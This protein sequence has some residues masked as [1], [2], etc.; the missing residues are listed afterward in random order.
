MA[1]ARWTWGEKYFMLRQ[2]PANSSAQKLG[3]MVPDGWVAYA[4]Q[5]H[6]F[7]KLFAFDADG[8]YP[9]WGCSVE[10]FTNDRFL[11]VE[12]LG[13]AQIVA[14]GAQVEHEENWFLFRDVPMPLN[15]GDVDR[16]I[17]PK[18]KSSQSL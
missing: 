13:P 12:T 9:D 10:T 11:E 14:P 1:D 17:L 5:N 2:D 15:D 18:V 8:H 7:L 16:H 3:A 4:N 6:L